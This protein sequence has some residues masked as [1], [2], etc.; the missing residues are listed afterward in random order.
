MEFKIKNRK[1]FR[2]F[3]NS[4]NPC[5][6]QNSMVADDLD[7][8]LETLNLDFESMNE[9]WGT[10]YTWKEGD[11]EYCVQFECS[12]VDEAVY[13]FLFQGFVRRF[14]IFAKCLDDRDLEK[15]PCVEMI[16]ELNQ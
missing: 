7:E 8:I 3:D 15:H 13:H 10:A 12:D 9:D 4:D 5:C 11:I 1:Y 14:F 2:E 6:W 16:Q